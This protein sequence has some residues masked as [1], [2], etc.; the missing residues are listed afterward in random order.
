M[1]FDKLA[2]NCP[3]S[4]SYHQTRACNITEYPKEC[5]EKKCGVWYWIKNSLE[6]KNE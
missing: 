2:E 3:W 1:E 4:T 5:S 6:S